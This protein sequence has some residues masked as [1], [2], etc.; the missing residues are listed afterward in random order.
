MEIKE[1]G[2]YK[3]GGTYTIKT[4]DNKEYCVDNRLFSKT[5][6]S[7]YL[8]YPDKGF[9]IENQEEIKNEIFEAVGLFIPEDFDYRPGLVELMG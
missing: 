4:V 7:V 1:I 2:C 9:L 3:D 5:K 6:G 8:G